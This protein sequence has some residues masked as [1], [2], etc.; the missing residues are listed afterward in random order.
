MTMSQN[1]YPHN[2]FLPLGSILVQT[3][4]GVNVGDLPDILGDIDLGNIILLDGPPVRLAG[5]DN[6]AIPF[7]GQSL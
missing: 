5:G 4:H 2:H 3:K 7:L 1:I 6:K